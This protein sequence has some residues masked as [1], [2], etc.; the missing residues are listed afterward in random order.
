MKYKIGIVEDDIKK[1]LNTEFVGQNIFFY[2]ET[3]TT[4]E[5]AKANMI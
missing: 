3:D 4:N 1:S 5:R 2:D